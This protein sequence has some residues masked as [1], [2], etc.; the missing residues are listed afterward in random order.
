ML[1]IRRYSTHEV[2]IGVMGYGGRRVRMLCMRLPNASALGLPHKGNGLWGKP[3]TRM[4]CMW[5]CYACGYATHEV[6]LVRES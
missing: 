1:H 5:L 4:L 3:T 2:V 6:G